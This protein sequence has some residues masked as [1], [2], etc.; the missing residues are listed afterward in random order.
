MAK[1]ASSLK[2]PYAWATAPCGQ[3]SDS[4]GNVNP[5]CVAQTLWVGGGPTEIASVC[6]VVVLVV[7]QV[8]ADLVELA[9]ADAGEGQRKEHQQHVLG[10]T[11]SLQRDGLAVLVLQREVRR[12]DANVGSI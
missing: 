5:L 6:G 11:K 8:I 1:P 12:R 9:L 7:G 2:T 10:A 4:I 3:K